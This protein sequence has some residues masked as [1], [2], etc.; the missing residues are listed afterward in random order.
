[1]KVKKFDKLEENYDQ[2]K[3]INSAKNLLDVIEFL[4]WVA[5]DEQMTPGYESYSGFLNLRLDDFT[6]SKD[7]K[8]KNKLKN[9]D[10]KR[11]MLEFLKLYNSNK[12]LC[13]QLMTYL[14][15]SVE[16]NPDE[17]ETIFYAV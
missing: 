3:H 13:T 17:E 8:F 2:Q 6:S 9:I 14:G 10:C 12:N 15:L 5:E 7:T 1:M 11:Q 16:A 4:K